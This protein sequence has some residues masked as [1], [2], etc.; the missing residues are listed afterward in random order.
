MAGEPVEQ[1]SP[2]LA[3][4]P[5]DP[6]GQRRLRNPQNAGGGRERSGFD[7]RSNGSQIIQVHIRGKA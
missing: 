2:E 6:P 1:T 7:D 3:L 4:Q 5:G